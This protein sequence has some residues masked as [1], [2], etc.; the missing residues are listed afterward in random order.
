M[1]NFKSII[2][3]ERNFN[4]I[5]RKPDFFSLNKPFFVKKI[6][7]SIFK[8]SIFAGLTVFFGGCCVPVP[9]EEETP[10]DCFVKPFAFLKPFVYPLVTHGSTSITQK[11][12]LFS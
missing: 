1:T 12:L 10:F 5:L 4:K 8:A 2:G 9:G 7:T 6:L 3:L 11:Q